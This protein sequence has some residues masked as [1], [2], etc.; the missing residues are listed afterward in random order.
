LRRRAALAFE[1]RLA[2]LAWLAVSRAGHV[3]R[4]VAVRLGLRAVR[5]VELRGL[6]AVESA[7]GRA[8]STAGGLVARRSTSLVVIVAIAAA[9][10][11]VLAV[12]GLGGWR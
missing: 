1:R 8:L 10:G 4:L 7:T 2:F 9:L 5:A 12:A 11:I 6:P 3:W